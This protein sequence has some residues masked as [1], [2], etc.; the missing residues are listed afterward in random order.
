MAYTYIHTQPYRKYNSHTHQ[1][2]TGIKYPTNNFWRTFFFCKQKKYEI[3][4]AISIIN[5]I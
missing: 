1:K 2:R 3:S 4:E 5:K